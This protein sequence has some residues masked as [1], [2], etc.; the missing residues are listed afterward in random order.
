M[1]RRAVA[2]LLA[3]ALLG[4]REQDANPHDAAASDRPALALLTGLPLAFGEGFSLDSA[5]HPAL[6]RLEQDFTV[7][8]VDGP[9]QLGSTRLLLAAQPRALTAE[10]LVALDRWVRGGGRLLLLADPW[11][12]W[13]SD[14]PLGHPE[15]PPV[16][17]ADTG[18][19]AHWGL[20][21][22]RPS[23]PGTGTVRRSLG[24]SKV[25]AS[26]PG[27][28]S[29]SGKGCEVQGDGFV[30]RCRIGR[31]AAVIVADADFIQGSGDSGAEAL[32]AELHRLSPR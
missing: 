20:S 12:S 9:D 27:T 18:L 16:E 26:T 22:E 6:Q 23:T 3:L 17:F 11:L 15:R 24:G 31:G 25:E 1:S 29:G 8:L 32:V 10:R 13:H 5:R 14:L 19:L 7:T 4:C 21:L 30:A 28:I 2:A